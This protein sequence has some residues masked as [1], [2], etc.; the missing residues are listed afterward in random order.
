MRGKK[1]KRKRATP[2]GET[3]GTLLRSKKGKGGLNSGPMQSERRVIVERFHKVGG[4]ILRQ[5]GEMVVS[6][7]TKWCF[8]K[9]EQVKGGFGTGRKSQRTTSPVARNLLLLSPPA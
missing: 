1:E 3:G 2:L 6:K 5:R 7:K 8:Q 4:L 9:W